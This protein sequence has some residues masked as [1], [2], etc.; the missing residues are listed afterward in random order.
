MTE[1]SLDERAKIGIE[2]TV[3]FFHSLGIETKLS[4]YITDYKGTGVEIAR[5]LTERGMIALGEHG[6]LT[7]ADAEKIIELSY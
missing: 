7:P 2:K 3:S 4:K 1:G 5:R 6:T